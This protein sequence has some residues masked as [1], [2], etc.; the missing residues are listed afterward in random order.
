MTQSSGGFTSFSQISKSFLKRQKSLGAQ[1]TFRSR[2]GLHNLEDLHNRSTK[3]TCKERERP[4]S[5]ESGKAPVRPFRECRDEFEPLLPCPGKHRSHH[6][7]V[8]AP[9]HRAR[10]VHQLS[11]ARNCGFGFGFRYFSRF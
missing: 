9:I 4:T 2:E 10:A 11:D 1:D 5:V 6:V 8:L 3:E 7:L